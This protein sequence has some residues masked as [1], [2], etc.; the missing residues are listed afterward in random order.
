MNG[1]SHPDL[2]K[3]IQAAFWGGALLGVIVSIVGVLAYE[4]WQDRG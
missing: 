3:L 2:I 1:L 4:S